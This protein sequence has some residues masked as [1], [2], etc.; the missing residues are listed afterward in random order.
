MGTSEEEEQKSRVEANLHFCFLSLLLCLDMKV[1]LL[2]MILT[3]L[4]IKL[5]NQKKYLVE[6]KDAGGTSYGEK[7]YSGDSGDYTTFACPVYAVGIGIVSG[8]STNTKNRNIDNYLKNNLKREVNIKSWEVCGRMCQGIAPCQAWTWIKHG[9]AINGIRKIENGIPYDRTNDCYLFATVPETYHD[10][11]AITGSRPCP[12][13]F[14]S[15]NS[16]L[17]P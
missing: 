15:K 4:C 11:N 9:S 13:N 5:T 7:K 12:T 10:P 8:L 3:L 6:M 16:S 17:P 1:Q 14:Q 2:I